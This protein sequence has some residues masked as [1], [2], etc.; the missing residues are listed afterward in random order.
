MP[1]HEFHY[2]WEYDL[3]SSPEKLWPFAADTNRFNHDTGVPSLE[4]PAEPSSRP[5]KSGRKLLRLKAFGM[6]IEWEELPFE[7]VRPSKIGVTRN[8]SKGP[9]AKLVVLVELTPNDGGGTK[10]TY[11]VWAKPNSLLGLIAIPIQIGLI[12]ARRFE[13]AFRSY[14]EMAQEGQAEELASNEREPAEAETRRLEL[15]SQRLQEN[16]VTKSIANGLVNHVGRASEMELSRIRPYALADNWG[17]SRRAV[18]EACLQATRIGLLDLQWDLLCPMCRGPQ[19]SSGSLRDIATNVHCEGCQID[20]NVNFDR[21][22][23]LTFRPN[24]TIRLVDPK[25]YCLGSPYRTPHVVCQQLLPPKTDREITLPLEQGSYRLRTLALHGEQPLAVNRNGATSITLEAGSKGWS[26]EEL[27]ISTRSTI[28]LINATDQEQLFVIERTEWSDQAATAA[29]VTALQIFRDLFSTEALRPGEKISV[30]T[31]TI[32]FTDL[33][34]S[35]QLYREIGDATAFGRVLN[36]FDV[37]RKA[38]ADE[39][40]AVVKTIGDS[41][42]AVFREPERALRAMLRAQHDLANPIDNREPLTLKAGLHM[43]PCIAVTLN[44]RLDYFGSTVNMA[45]RLESLSTGSD[46]IISQ[47]IFDDPEVK[48]LTNEANLQVEPF[49]ITLKGFTDERFQLLR[50]GRRNVASVG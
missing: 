3:K 30:G 40:G 18:L 6:P 17:E 47:A 20:F 14:D 12:S 2:R 33:R 25:T 42:M 50:V 22:V 9:V 26:K 23:E 28:K 27:Q 4:S 31:L 44:D 49:E 7:W 39:D 10:V 41:V 48:Q 38:I 37:L 15:L 19:E 1:K 24:A 8:Y 32:L 43:G 36:H 11:Q 34:N 21:F 46:V 13:S 45:S 35:T 16:G 29:E 5:S